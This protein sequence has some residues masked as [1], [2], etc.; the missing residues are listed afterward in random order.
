MLGSSGP[1]LNDD[2]RSS[3]YC[4]A[5]LYS[6]ELCNFRS[7]AMQYF[8]NRILG[9]LGSSDDGDGDG[10]DVIDDDDDDDDVMVA[11]DNNNIDL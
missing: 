4:L 8:R 5:A 1:V 11:C 7:N 3:Q 10:W 2:N 6:F 9:G